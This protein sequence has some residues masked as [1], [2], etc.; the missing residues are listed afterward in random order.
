MSLTMNSYSFVFM[1]VLFL[2]TFRNML[3]FIR[4]YSEQEELSTT[5]LSHRHWANSLPSN[6]LHGALNAA[7]P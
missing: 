3:K 2:N 6:P 1:A 7:P 4:R 5:A